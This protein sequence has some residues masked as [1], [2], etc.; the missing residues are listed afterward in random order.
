MR[1]S[2]FNTEYQEKSI[3][4]KIV[5][6][7]E[8]ISEA[9]KA[10]LR[11]H[12]KTIGISPIQIQILIFITYHKQELCNVSYLAKEFNVTKPTISDAVKVLIIKNLVKKNLSTTDNRGYSIIPTNE[13]TKIVKKTEEYAIPIKNT[14]NDTAEKELITLYSSVNKLIYKLN[15]NGILNVQ[16]TCYACGFYEI[17]KRKHFCNLLETD[18]MDKEIRIDCPEFK[19]S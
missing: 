12:A 3:S 16:R 2:I 10:L 1:E 11:Q 19:T 4:S 18:L 7:L 17:K 5:I 13:G 15:R 9:F 6:G 8:R 14:I